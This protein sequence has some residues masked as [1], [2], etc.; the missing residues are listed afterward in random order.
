MNPDSA[1]IS[2]NVKNVEGSLIVEGGKAM[3]TFTRSVWIKGGEILEV[4][5]S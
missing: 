4:M 5:C 2:L 1:I 3:I